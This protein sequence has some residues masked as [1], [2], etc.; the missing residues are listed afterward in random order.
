MRDFWLSC[1]HHF[2][3]RDSAGG[4]IVTDDFLKVYLAR[5]ELLPPPEA[6]PAE[7]NLHSALLLDPR[8][9][10]TPSEILA[11]ADVDAREN[12]HVLASF[13]DYLLAHKTLEAGY[14]DL[15]RHGV[16]RIPPL[17]LNQ[18]VHAI[19]RNA[20]NDVTDPW[21]L[22]AGELFFRTQRV[23]LHENSLI[24]ADEETIVGTSQRPVSPLVS[25]LGLPAEAAIEVLNNENAETYW[26]RSDRF[27]MALDLTSGRQGLSAVAKVIELWTEH[28]LGFGVTIEA[29]PELR[30]APV[31][32]Y[33][34][35]D[36]EATGIGDALWKGHE[37]DED[38]MRRVVGLFR[39][40]FRDTGLMIDDLK[41]D[42]VYLV[43]A[44]TRDHLIRMKPQNLVTGLPIK[45]SE[46]VG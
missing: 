15:I 21:I 43:L 38:A 30:D 23:T 2:L 31:T 13:R 9:P 19:L 36:S 45:H 35:L 16:G 32:W 18:L 24:A 41:G 44:M 17:F 42:L 3:D 11:I 8:R 1:G 22:R 34:G 6:C 29:I 40:T 28:L 5:P 25:M 14:V 33:V 46:A 12:W 20:L 26:Q 10:V 7:R 39:L 4:Y 27:D 37:L